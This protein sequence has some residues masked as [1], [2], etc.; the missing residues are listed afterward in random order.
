MT[1]RRSSREHLLQCHIHVT[2]VSCIQIISVRVIHHVLRFS[3]KTSRIEFHRNTQQLVQTNVPSSHV[4]PPSGPASAQPHTR[5]CQPSVHTPAVRFEGVSKRFP[6]VQALTG[7]LL[8][9]KRA[10]VVVR[11][12]TASPGK[13][14]CMCAASVYIVAAARALAEGVRNMMNKES[15]LFDARK[16]AATTEP[17]LLVVLDRRNDCVSPLLSQWTYQVC[18][19]M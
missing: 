5:Q 8:S 2:S 7:V 1:C 13:C 17:L 12:E 10:S 18:S 4:A 19:V 15:A 3:L 14:V 16:H 6:G 11:Y 9:L